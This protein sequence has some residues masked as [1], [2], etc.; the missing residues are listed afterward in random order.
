MK[1]SEAWGLL[2]PDGGR[3]KEQSTL[4]LLRTYCMPFKY[5]QLSICYICT[6]SLLSAGQSGGFREG[7]HPDVKLLTLG[8]GVELGSASRPFC[9]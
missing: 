3:W 5:S 6:E 9:F 1:R 8:S 2:R 7:Y 4:H